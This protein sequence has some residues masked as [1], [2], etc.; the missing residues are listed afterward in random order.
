MFSFSISN[1][2]SSAERRKKYSNKN[3]PITDSIMDYFFLR[4]S[5]PKLS[6]KEMVLVKSLVASPIPCFNCRNFN[7]LYISISFCLFYLYI[8]LQ[9]YSSQNILT[10]PWDRSI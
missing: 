8:S 4:D 2:N 7:T 6:K 3:V 9:L 5:L 1:E 10:E